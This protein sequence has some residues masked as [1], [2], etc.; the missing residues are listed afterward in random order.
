VA[1][2]E[3]RVTFQCRDIIDNCSWEVRAGIVYF[4]NDQAGFAAKNA[5]ELKR[6]VLAE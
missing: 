4:D 6:L 1:L 5:P 3:G 2:D